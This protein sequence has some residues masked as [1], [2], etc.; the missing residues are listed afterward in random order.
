MKLNQ[1]VPSPHVRKEVMSKIF[2]CPAHPPAH[3]V[4][5]YSELSQT[6]TTEVFVKIVS[7]VEKNSSY[8]V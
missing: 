3:S 5:A 1:V 2:L 4:K 7:A 8:N 6:T